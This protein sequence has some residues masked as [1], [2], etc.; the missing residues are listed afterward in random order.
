MKIIIVGLEEKKL[1]SEYVKHKM[2]NFLHSPRQ[3]ANRRICRK[4]N[5]CLQKEKIVSES[6]RNMKQK[7]K[8]LDEA[9][10]KFHKKR[11]KVCLT[12]KS[13]FFGLLI[14]S[15]KISSALVRTIFIW[16]WYMLACIRLSSAPF[17]K[18]SNVCCVYTEVWCRLGTGY[19]SA[20]TF[21]FF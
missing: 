21:N 3:L 8:K 13:E 20:H 9:L 11:K 15:K 17:S 16:A 10:V 1:L 19:F 7:I 6:V 5:S 4:W 14:M 12:R 18:I 2:R